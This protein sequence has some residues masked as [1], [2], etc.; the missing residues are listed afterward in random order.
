VAAFAQLVHPG[1]GTSFASGSVAPALLE[2]AGDERQTMTN[3]GPAAMLVATSLVLVSG[4][5][6]A[7]TGRGGVGSRPIPRIASSAPATPT[8]THTASHTTSSHPSR[9]RPTSPYQLPAAT[10]CGLFLKGSDA[11]LTV[12]GRGADGLCSQYPVDLAKSGQ[13]WS[14]VY[15]P[16]EDPDGMTPVCVLTTTDGQYTVVVADSSPQVDG[17]QRCEGFLSTGDWTEDTGAEAGNSCH[18]RYHSWNDIELFRVVRQPGAPSYTVIFV[19]RDDQDLYAPQYL[20]SRYAR[21]GEWL[22]M[23]QGVSAATRPSECMAIAAP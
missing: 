19:D 15:Q 13:Y 9:A 14:Q 22:D 2:F 6:S 7:V 23:N 12:S 11:R 16:A 10:M 5:A 3:M 4:C 18:L 17:Q 1:L 8:S 21:P 20:S